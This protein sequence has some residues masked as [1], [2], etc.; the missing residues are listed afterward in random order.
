MRLVGGF[1]HQA[2]GIGHIGKLQ[3]EEPAGALRIAV[4][5]GGIGGDRLVDLDDFTI[6]RTIDVGSSFHGFD[7]CRIAALLEGRADFRQFDEDEVTEL[8]GR[9]KRDANGRNA[10]FDL[11]PLVFF[12]EFQH[13]RSSLDR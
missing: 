10:A 5:E 11:Q 4:D 13:G 9:M 6:E 7:R 8:F 12:G 3:L 1:I 2:I